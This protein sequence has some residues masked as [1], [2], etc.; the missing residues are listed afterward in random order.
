MKT[1]SPK[2]IKIKGTFRD[3]DGKVITFI[4]DDS[5]QRLIFI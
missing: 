1:K 4:N 5:K 2:T 3:R